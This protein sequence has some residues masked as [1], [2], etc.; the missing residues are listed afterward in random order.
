M[1]KKP[2]YVLTIRTSKELK[3][4]VVAKATAR[5]RNANKTSQYVLDLILRDLDAP[6]AP[7]TAEEEAVTTA[8]ASGNCNAKKVIARLVDS[9]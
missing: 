5:Y 8:I 9:L 1:E 3:E 6:D 4:Q 2:I 7:L